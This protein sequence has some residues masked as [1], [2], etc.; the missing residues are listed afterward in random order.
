MAPNM[1]HWRSVLLERYV[2]API[3]DS[4]TTTS[5][6]PTGRETAVAF[7]DFLINLPAKKL[8]GRMRRSRTRST[9]WLAGLWR[10]EYGN[11]DGVLLTLIIILRQQT[12]HDHI[13]NMS[14]VQRNRGSINKLFSNCS[15]FTPGI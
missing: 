12:R 2:T 14:V 15:I 4:I 6:I 8:P 7:G 5:R 1:L 3:A 13:R 10:M 9:L 11:R